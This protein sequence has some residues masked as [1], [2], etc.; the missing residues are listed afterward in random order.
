[1]KA[2]VTG[3]SGFIG[4]HLLEKLDG[5][6]IC[7]ID[8]DPFV[9]GQSEDHICMDLASF[10]IDTD[11]SCDTLFHLA[12]S[13][14]IRDETASDMILNNV[15]ALEKTLD[16]VNFK[17]IVFTSTSAVYGDA[18][19]VP[20]PENE[21]FSPIS[22][23]AM[24]KCMGEWMVEKHC[25]EKDKACLILRF[26]NVVGQGGHGV[27]PD[28]IHKLQADPKK[29]VILGDG[30]QMKSYVHVDDIVRVMS[31]KLEGTY[32]V[33]TVDAISVRDVAD[34]VCHEMG[35]NPKYDYTGGNR[36]WKGDVTK[37]GLDI[38]KL[39]EAR[40][41]PRMTSEEAVRKATREL[42]EE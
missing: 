21:P 17:K 36:G 25:N 2:V 35:L 39:D 6:D 23:Y 40:L 22:Y 32:N 24:T 9:R 10:D 38:Y 15:V 33:S 12:A 19:V 20:T 5:N 8:V 7:A 41:A 30:S 29:L 4:K 11:L 14:Q 28:F 13:A 18:K 1:M 42:L 3:S 26:G 27:I 31:S 34:I 16:N 37:M